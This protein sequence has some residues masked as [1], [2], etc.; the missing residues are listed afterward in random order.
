MLDLFFDKA[1]VAVVYEGPYEL[2][3][4]LNPQFNGKFKVIDSYPTKSKSYFF[5]HKNYPFRQKII[6]NYLRMVTSVRGRQFLNLF[7]QDVL[8]RV[9]VSDLEVY[10]GLYHEHKLL[11]KK[12]RP[13]H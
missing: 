9:N 13:K 11:I 5:V 3:K 12:Y 7:Q 2:M 6:D 10:D 8:E 1:D 4:D